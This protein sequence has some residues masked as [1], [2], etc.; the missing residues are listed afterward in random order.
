[1]DFK[2]ITDVTA[3][4]ITR[5]EAKLH[6]RID[7]IGGSHADDTLVDALITAARQMA[8]HYTGRAFAGQTLEATLREF[9]EDDDYID[10]P[11]PP[12]ATITHVKYYDGDGT[13]QTLAT[14]NYALSAYGL[15]RRVELTYGNTWPATRDMP[16]AVQVRFVTGYAATGAAAG[17]TALPKAARQGLLLIIGHLYENRQAG[18]EMPMAARA[19]LDT[20]KVYGR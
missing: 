9:P 8:E 11:M 5:A 19:L 4:P 3:E 13:L 7:D 18:D 15:S 10:L 12:V 2:V 14:A 20:L 16:D 1:M 17:Y 6:L